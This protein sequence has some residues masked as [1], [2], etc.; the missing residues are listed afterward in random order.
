M[1][2]D[3]TSL[4]QEER[5]IKRPKN[6]NLGFLKKHRQSNQ[7]S[8]GGPSFPK[9]PSMEFEQH[10][11][12]KLHHA[13]LNFPLPPITDDSTDFE[14]FYSSSESLEEMTVS[15]AEVRPT[16]EGNLKSME[17]NFVSKHS[18]HSKN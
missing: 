16:Y 10:F 12:K 4:N 14:T 18:A 1:I 3:N 2:F 15:Y 5:S 6:A 11:S 9:F 13:G 17:R 8:C 7:A